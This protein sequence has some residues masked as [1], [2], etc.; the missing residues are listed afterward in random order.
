[1]KLSISHLKPG[2]VLDSSIYSS[3]G[4]LLLNWD[5][6]LTAKNIRALKEMGILAANIRSDVALNLDFEKTDNVL[7]D[8]IKIE[9]L[10]SVRN[11]VEKNMIKESYRTLVELIRNIITEILSGKSSIGGLSEIVAY[12]SYTYAHSVDVCIL[13]III[14]HEMGLS[15]SVLIKLGIGSLLHDLGKIRIPIEILNKTGS[16]TEEEFT[17]IKK[18]TVLGHKMANY[19]FEERLSKES[20]SII[21]NH[22]ER[23]NGSGYP[24]GLKGS[25]LSVLDMIC[26]IADMYSAMTTDR[27]YRKAL[28]YSEVYEMLQ[29]SAGSY[30]SFNIVQ[31]FAQSIQPYPVGTLVRMNNG[32]KACVIKTNPSLPTRPIVK[33]LPTKEIIDLS[34]N[35]SS[36]IESQL[37]QEE[38]SELISKLS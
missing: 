12:D 30:F 6:T 32:H 27:S 1:M 13:S 2:M 4:K 38:I 25:E 33:I 17:E 3:Q 20:I 18:H 31:A 11:F 9:V 37:S 23:Y 19:E 8:E 22:H 5:H 10:N 7:D 21:L 29:G 34:G 35:L 26:G 15:K 24:R 14:G 16:L 36:V 28:F